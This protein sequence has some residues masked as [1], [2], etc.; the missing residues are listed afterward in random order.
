VTT[1]PALRL[2]C[3]ALEGMAAHRADHHEVQTLAASRPRHRRGDL[4]VCTSAATDLRV[5]IN[6]TTRMVVAV[7]RGAQHD[8]PWRTAI[9]GRQRKRR[10]HQSRTA[11]MR[12]QSSRS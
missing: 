7:W 9:T 1:A 5:L 2:T 10:H 3:H 4:A 8:G 12:N 6:P 11:H